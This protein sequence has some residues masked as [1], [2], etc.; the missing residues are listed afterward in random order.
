MRTLK[1]NFIA[2]LV[3]FAGILGFAVGVLATGFIFMSNNAFITVYREY[4]L[5]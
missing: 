1:V 5:K 4:L 2:A 3:L